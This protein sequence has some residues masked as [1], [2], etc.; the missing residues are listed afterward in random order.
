M[1]GR[2]MG[3]GDDSRI[4]QEVVVTFINGDPDLPLVI[5]SVYN[6]ANTPPYSLPDN[7][8]MMGM[9]SRSSKGGDGGTYNELVI[10]DK[11]MPKNF[12]LMHKKLQHE[13]RQ[14]CQPLYR[15]QYHHKK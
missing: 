14:G 3:L 4:G 7:K 8:S 2:Q 9:K 12:A 1:G 11:K 13:N 5:G 6:S 15:R 10:D